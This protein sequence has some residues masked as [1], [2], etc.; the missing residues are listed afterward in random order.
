L[1]SGPCSR[2]AGIPY[3]KYRAF[4]EVATRLPRFIDDVYNAKRLLS[5][6]GYRSPVKFEEEHARQIVQ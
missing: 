6:L 3:S 4:E 1:I 2:R 5:A